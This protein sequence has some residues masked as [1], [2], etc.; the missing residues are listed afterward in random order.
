MVVENNDPPESQ[1]L[2]HKL[3]EGTLVKGD[4]D[5]MNEL[6]END[7]RFRQQ[8][9]GLVAL[10]ALLQ[11]EHVPVEAFSDDVERQAAVEFFR[12]ESQLDLARAPFSGRRRW[13]S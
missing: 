3:C 2:F 10:E 6:L 7:P 9:L 1:R 8:Y 4:A 11:L 12:R 5:R 13:I